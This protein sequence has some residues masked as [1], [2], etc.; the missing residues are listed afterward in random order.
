MTRKVK[1][2]SFRRHE[3]SYDAALQ[4]R[5]RAAVAEKCGHRALNNMSKAQQTSK[6]F[7]AKMTSIIDMS[8]QLTKRLGKLLQSSAV[9]YQCMHQ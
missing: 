5:A 2:I 7:G 4:A 3:T 1:F 9:V 6:S 8:C